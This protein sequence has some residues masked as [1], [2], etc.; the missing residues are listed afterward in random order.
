MPIEF[1]CSQ[2]GKSLRTP[3]E[4][5]GKQAKCPD[6][7]AIQTVP[8]GSGA[9]FEQNVSSPPPA[10]NPFAESA[11]Q[12]GAA[13]GARVEDYNPYASPTQSQP[14]S[15]PTK[16]EGLQYT[17]IGPDDILVRLYEVFTKH[18]GPCILFGLILF[19]VNLV[20]NVVSQVGTAVGEALGEVWLQLV[21]VFVIQVISF[22][23]Q[24]F[25]QLGGCLFGIRLIRHDQ[26]QLGLVFQGGRY[27]G[28]GFVYAFLIG[29]VVAIIFGLFCI[30]GAILMI[31][32]GPG[33]GVWALIAGMFVAVPIVMYIFLRYSLGFFFI[34]DQNM[35]FAEAAK[36][37]Y[38][39]MQGNMLST[40]VAGLAVAGISLV[41]MCT[42]VGVLVVMPLQP[43][44]MTLVYLRATGQPVPGA[45]KATLPVKSMPVK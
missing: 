8:T 13:P 6:C 36:A 14:R 19:G 29:L 12:R 25:L 9:G 4:S 22:V 27:F 10:A 23:V 20:V 34:V 16:L 42:C 26:P 5:A 33:V 1:P 24:T 21:I 41:L 39:Y 31:N 7:G 32:D 35:G 18:L 15:E 2:C 17:Q 45:T 11:A 40:F 43:L 3:D 28:S 37:S 44:M 38:Q 30:P